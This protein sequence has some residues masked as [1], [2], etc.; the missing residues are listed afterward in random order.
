[1]R[2]R[3]NILINWLLI[4]LI[5][6]A[7]CSVYVVGDMIADINDRNSLYAKHL[8]CFSKDNNFILSSRV[9]LPADS[10]TYVSDAWQSTSWLGR[11]FSTADGHAAIENM[12]HTNRPYTLGLHN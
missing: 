6:Q 7:T 10:Y 12:G 9:V 4:M 5:S 1:M 2:L 8:T 3:L 11:C